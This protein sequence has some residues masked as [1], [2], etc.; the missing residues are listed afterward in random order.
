MAHVDPEGVGA[1][2]RTHHVENHK[3]SMIGKYHNH[4]L[5]QSNISFWRNYF[6]EF[7]DACHGGHLGYLNRI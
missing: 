4:V 5:V 2:V 7:Q 1:G 3:L 6:E